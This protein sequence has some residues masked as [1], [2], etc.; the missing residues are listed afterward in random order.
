MKD[1]WYT[2]ALKYLSAI[3]VF[4][5]VAF[6]VY[7]I[8]SCSFRHQ[9]EF[10]VANAPLWSWDLTFENYYTVF[11]KAD[12]GR[13]IVNSCIYTFATVALTVAIAAMGS[14]AFAHF[15]N[16]RAAKRM[17]AFLYI[18]QMLPSLM[19]T[20][21]MFLIYWKLGILNTYTSLILVYSCSGNLVVAVTMLNGYFAEVSY[22]LFD[23][24]Y[25]DG[26]SAWQAFYRVLLPLARA[27]MICVAI[28]TF[29]VTWQEFSYAQN[30]IT[31]NKMF[32]VT[33]GLAAFNKERG[34]DWGGLFAASTLIMVPTL[35]MMVTVQNYFIDSLAGAVKE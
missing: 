16:F 1:K 4:V 12:F 18:Q 30:L 13:C 2:R 24:A 14:H 3:A 31:D 15:K 5:V 11:M 27:G 19:M 20:I 21:P 10:M 26:A 35:V 29:I 9:S 25:I 6:P 32:N 33:V 7:W 22:D 8:I 17:Q 23:A 34:K 28:Y